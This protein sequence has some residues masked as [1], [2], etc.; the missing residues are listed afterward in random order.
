MHAA[1]GIGMAVAAIELIPRAHER[2]ETWLLALALVVGSLAAA[3]L[4]RVTRAVSNRIGRKSGR[5]TTWGAFAA[6]GIDLLSD[7]LMT[8][9]GGA[10]AASLG[11]LLAVSQVFGNLPGGFAIAANFQ[12][13]GV[14][15][16]R[17]WT[18]LALYPLMPLIGAFAG[19][20]VLQDAGALLRG[21]VLGLFAGLL[22][23]ATIEDIIPEADRPDAPRH[24]SSPAFA[25]GFVA[26]LLMASYI[27]E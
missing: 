27:G 14:P 24:I 25:L 22:L 6:I 12:S 16:A 26:L 1:A 21:V 7:G 2:I 19:F 3:G 13:A 20:L 11:V 8:G 18:A 17:R 23:T 5:A 9:A 10:V 15:R 4:A